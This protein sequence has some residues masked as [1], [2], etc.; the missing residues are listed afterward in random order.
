MKFHVGREVNGI[1]PTVSE[2]IKDPKMHN[3]FVRKL[4]STDR[5]PRKSKVLNAK[6]YS[7]SKWLALN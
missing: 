7:S 3:P 5:T 4:L 6:L 1:I 2:A